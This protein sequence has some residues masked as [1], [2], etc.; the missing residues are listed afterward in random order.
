MRIPANTEPANTEPAATPRLSLR[1]LSC[2]FGAVRALDGIDLDVA[3]GEIVG[4]LG[5]SGCGKSTLLRVVA[6]LEPQT[7]GEVRLDGRPLGPATPPELRGIGLMFQDYALFPHLSVAGNVGF[8]LARRP[9]REAAAIVAE[10]LAQ[11]GLS[12]RADAFPATLSGGEA[13][14]AA[15]AR[16]LA[17]EPRVLLLDE[18][19]SN[20]D[21]RLRERI[22][23]ETLALLRSG[24]ITALLVTHDPEEAL[25]GCDRIVLM[26]EGRIAQAG[27]PEA[28]YRQPASRFAARFLGE[29]VEAEG[30]CRDG[31]VQ[32]PLGRFPA[33]A[34]EE[35][36]ALV[37]LLR[38]EAVR[39]AESGIPAEVVSSAF[40]GATA[41]LEIA[42]DGL[43]APV[44]L[45]VP[46][47]GAPC[48]GTRVRIA[49]DRGTAVVFSAGAD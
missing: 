16:A 36:A 21:R 41:R 23:A 8:G 35:G 42:V 34:A 37:V 4:L 49:I 46:P 2:R 43:G 39:L 31:A 10:R 28:V 12:H 11:V 14:R 9:R 15:L 47:A 32:T 20:L 27:T 6:G 22:R 30:R 38:P 13:Q 1:D 29:V 45:S 44:G 3:P 48:P 26:R 19:F 7:G 33:P 5:D 40:R 17:P 25:D 24:G 18:P